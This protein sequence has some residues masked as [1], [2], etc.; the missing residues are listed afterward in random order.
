[1]KGYEKAS[2]WNDDGSVKR[3]KD[4]VRIYFCDEDGRPDKD[5][6]DVEIDRGANYVKNLLALSGE[7]SLASARAWG[8]KIKAIGSEGGVMTI[9]LSPRIT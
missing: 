4:V 6:N 1:M 5:P 9:H 3:H 2:I 8:H 7:V